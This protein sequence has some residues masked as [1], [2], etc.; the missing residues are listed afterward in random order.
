MGGQRLQRTVGDEHLLGLR[1]GDD[2]EDEDVRPLRR[3]RGRGGRLA[4]R[5]GE[6]L[7][8]SR[9]RVVAA[10]AMA[11]AEQVARHRQAHRAEADKGDHE[12]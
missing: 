4:G 3:L 1:G 11:T 9:T 12:I 6:R 10:D 2:H 8:G 5:L 7:D